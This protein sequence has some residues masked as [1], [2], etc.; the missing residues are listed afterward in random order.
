VPTYG[1]TDKFEEVRRSGTSFAAPLVSFAGSLL[2]DLGDAVRIKSRVLSSGRYFSALTTKVRSSRMLDV[3]TAL[4]VQF[5]AIRDKEGAL[6]LGRI[7]WPKGGRTVC[8]GMR[9]REQIAQI[10]LVDDDHTKVSILLKDPEDWRKLKFPGLCSLDADS[11]LAQI[12]FQEIDE[13][14]EALSLK[15]PE[16]LDIRNLQSIT[17]CEVCYWTQ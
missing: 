14:A 17:F 3:P 12:S 6:R 9:L 16:F 2:R 13:P 5:D 10:S 11:E 1:W 8:R 7:D 15:K 4:A